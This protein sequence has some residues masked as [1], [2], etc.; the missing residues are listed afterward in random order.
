MRPTFAL[1]TAIVLAA[2]VLVSCGT[3]TSNTFST[4]FYNTPS[5]IPSNAPGTILRF[6]TMNAPF[7]ESQAWRVLYTSTG[8]NGET[9]AVSGMVFAPAG[10]IPPG[11]R[12]VVSWAHPTT[13]IDDQCAPSRSPKPYDDVQGLADFLN[14]GWVVVATDYQGLGTDGMH[15]YLVGASEAQGTID[16]VRA[17]R[18]LNETGASSNYFVFGHSQG[19]QAA[20]FAGQM[21]S[22]YAPELQLLGVAAAAPAGLLVPLFQADK[23]TAAGAVL[24]SYAVVSWSDI[25]GYDEATVVK[26]T[27]SGRVHAVSEKCVVGGSRLSDIE[28]GIN[29]LILKGRMWAADPATTAPWSNQFALNT[30]AQSPITTPLLLTQGTADKIIT[31]STTAELTAMYVAMGNNQATEQVMDG[32]D[33][34]K[35]GKASVP[36]VVPFFQRL[37]N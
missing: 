1:L 9:I 2:L 32:V 12:P 17:A 8:I 34:M 13:G 36:Y 28:L 3:T 10:P 19:G 4:S 15:P 21:A 6:E 27:L 25:F 22:T 20:L 11:G 14:L 23:N 24:G 37:V 5:S 31:P 33:H 35:A 18:N 30:A 7:P 16:I 29:D 26:P